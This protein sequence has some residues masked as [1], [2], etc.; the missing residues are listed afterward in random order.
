MNTFQFA[1]L[2]FRV[3]SL[4]GYELPRWTDNNTPRFKILSRRFQHQPAAQMMMEPV[5]AIPAPFTREVAGKSA[6]WAFSAA[7]SF[8]EEHYK[9]AMQLVTTGPGS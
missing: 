1:P 6:R 5:S 3:G 7:H 4:P 9:N 8:A 2:S